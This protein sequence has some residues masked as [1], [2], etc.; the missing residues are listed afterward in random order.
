MRG[1]VPILSAVLRRARF[2][3]AI[4]VQLTTTVAVVL[5]RTALTGPIRG[6]RG[7]ARKRWQLSKRWRYL[8]LISLAHINRVMK[9][10]ANHS[11]PKK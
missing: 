1:H 4:F 6:R 7:F 2:G 5:T 3:A 10:I 8:F 11:S 9:T